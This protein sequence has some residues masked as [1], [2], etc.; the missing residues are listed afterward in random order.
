MVRYGEGQ[1]EERLK[2]QRESVNLDADEGKER[3]VRDKQIQIGNL[4][5]GR[6]KK[7][8]DRIFCWPIC[9]RDE[10][11]KKR[12]HYEFTSTTFRKLYN[13][14]GLH[15]FGERE[16]HFF[17]PRKMCHIHFYQYDSKDK[18]KRRHLNERRRKRVPAHSKK[19]KK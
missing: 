11:D 16:N 3:A 7:E 17:H 1:V 8:P 6:T 18:G 15:T 4:M 5:V 12:G 19:K 10:K 13:V 2:T 9:G 14:R